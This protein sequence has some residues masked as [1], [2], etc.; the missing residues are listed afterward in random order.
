MQ[1][2]KP[3]KLA[4][5]VDGERPAVID[6]YGFSSTEPRGGEYIGSA[7]PDRDGE[8]SLDIPK[9]YAAYAATAT[10]KATSEMSP[11][12]TG[13]TDGDSLCDN[14][15][16]NGIDYDADGTPDLRL[17]DEGADPAKPD[18]FVEIDYQAG[19]RPHLNALYKVKQAFE[20]APKPI[21]LHTD[22]DE[23][24]TGDA[25]INADGRS[26]GAYDDVRD[27]YGGCG[28]FFGHEEDRDTDQC[29]ANLNARRLAYRYALFAGAETGGNSGSADPGGDAF[30]VTLGSFPREDIL[31]GGGSGEHGCNRQYDACLSE[32]EAA[33]FMHELGHTLG[34]L[35]GGDAKGEN[36]EPNYLSVMNYWYLTRAPLNIAAAGLLAQD[37]DRPRRGE[38]RR[39]PGVLRQLP[40][41]R[42]GAVDRRR[43][44]GLGPRVR[45]VPDLHRRR[46]RVAD[47]PRPA[48][49]GEQRGRDGPQ[50][51]RRR[52]QPRRARG[53]PGPRQLHRPDRH[54][55]LGAAA[56]VAPRPPRL[57]R[58]RLRK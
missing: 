31:L 33:V 39:G 36:N 25:V 8:W 28:T 40:A 50:R 6:V 45:P 10:D 56:L 38:V 51:P 58:G 21:T 26:R 47:Q 24:V 7:E 23:E 32:L 19:H 16:R 9:A 53:L 14:W 29:D 34:L 5:E 2:V 15:E 44:H 12:C 57:A 49:G 11:P 1:I 18:L 13:D 17:Q 55:R 20:L 41:A 27:F 54:R 22:I 35:H 43:H 37:P 42:R 46:H 48:P 30:V 3:G 52:A 4:G